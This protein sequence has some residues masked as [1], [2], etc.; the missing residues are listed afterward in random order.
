MHSF[1]PFLGAT[2]SDEIHGVGSDLGAMM[3]S[4][5]IQSSVCFN[6]GR[7]DTGM[8]LNACC[9]GVTPYLRRI[10]YGWSNLPI[11]AAKISEDALKMC[12]KLTSRLS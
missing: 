11:L 12:L 10:V 5:V 9:T 4:A 8:R 2:T 1:P 7:N 3:P 6:N